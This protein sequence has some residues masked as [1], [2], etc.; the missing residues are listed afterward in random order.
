M[1][2]ITTIATMLTI[3]IIFSGCGPSA[4]EKQLEEFVTVHVEKVKP[5]AKELRLAY[6]KAANTGNSEDYDKVSKLEFEI[7]QI[8][9]N[10]EEFAFLKDTKES[11]EVKDAKL[12]RQLDVLYNGYLEN[13]IEPQLL[14]EIVDSGTK[15]EKNFS[16]FRG[17]IG[18]EEVTTNEI[19]ELLKTEANSVK[20]KQAWLASKQVGPVVAADLIKLV[21][22]RNKAAR[23]VGFD[24][25]HTLSLTTAEQDVKELDGIFNKLYELT[26]V[27]FARLKIDLDR[28][29]AAK[30]GIDVKQ[31]RPWHYHDPFFQETPLV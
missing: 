23:E 11:G 25:Y 15:I 6:W 28:T 22:L 18:E 4:K 3:A 19:K 20:R 27:P 8:Y 16:T 30:Y 10:R 7:R 2:K 9:S 5:L 29:L 1:K 24:N 26:N 12:A 17:T 14:K 31:L 21:K 13:Q